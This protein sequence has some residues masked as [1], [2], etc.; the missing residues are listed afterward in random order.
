M[1]TIMQAVYFCVK[2]KQF[3]VFVFL[4][5]IQDCQ[6]RTAFIRFAF[7]LKKKAQHVMYILVLIA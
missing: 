1:V 3:C 7:F 5:I 4:G 6:Q 2:S